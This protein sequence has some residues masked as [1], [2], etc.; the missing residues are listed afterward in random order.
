MGYSATRM[1]FHRT[2][3]FR[4][5]T[6]DKCHWHFPQKTLDGCLLL[7]ILA[8]SKVISRWVLTYDNVHSWQLYSAAPLVDMAAS[9]MT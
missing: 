6:R 8:T 5:T 1:G 9:T 2:R 3:M 7:Y 4:L